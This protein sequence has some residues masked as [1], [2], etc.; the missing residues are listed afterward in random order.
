[1]KCERV[2][3]SQEQEWNRDRSRLSRAATVQ[4]GH[5]D[6]VCPIQIIMPSETKKK[7]SPHPCPPPR[8][9]KRQMSSAPKPRGPRFTGVGKGGGTPGSAQSAP[10]SSSAHWSSSTI[11]P[12]KAPKP[13]RRFVSQIPSAISAD[14]QLQEAMSALPANYNFEVAK[15]IWRLR[16]L[17]A[18]SVALQFPEGLLMF[19]TTIADILERFAGVSCVIMGDVTYGACCV[20]DLSAAA[21]GCQLL[22]HYGHSCLV[23]VDQMETQVLYVFVREPP[24]HRHHPHRRRCRPDPLPSFCPAHL[25]RAS[26]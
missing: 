3:K 10:S 12:Q 17:E 6:D 15:T 19:A 8:G 16:Q 14:P 9:T 5:S 18:T 1:M 23:P 25:R 26:L 7:M 21:L 20:D 22:V 4:L 24:P 2:A 11:V 13:R